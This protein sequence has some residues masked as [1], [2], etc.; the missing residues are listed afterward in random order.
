MMVLLAPAFLLGQRTGN[1]V[2]D[3]KLM[4][5]KIIRQLA[6]FTRVWDEGIVDLVVPDV[7][8]AGTTVE[9]VAAKAALYIPSGKTEE[10]QLAVI[11]ERRSG[12]SYVVRGYQTFYVMHKTDMLAVLVGAG[13]VSW[14][15]S[16][17]RLPTS[18]DEVVLISRFVSQTNDEALS[19]SDQR[20]VWVSLR[21]G[22]PDEF[23]LAGSTL[24]TSKVAFP[25][26]GAIGLANGVLRLDLVSD[27]AKYKGTFW[28]DL[29]AGTLLRSVLDGREVFKAK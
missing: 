21:P 26:V 6:D 17:F 25:T 15:G 18:S 4:K 3:L 8:D 1:N 10:F 14:I 7:S 20:R 22:V 12:Q 23:F 5:P 19:R 2:Q 11:S 13:K 24:E 16:Y 9:K 27:R 28:I 29:D